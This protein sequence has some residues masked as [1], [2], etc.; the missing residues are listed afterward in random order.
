MP[1]GSDGDPKGINVILDVDG[2]QGPIADL[3]FRFD[4]GSCSGA[5]GATGVGLTHAWVGDLVAKLIAPDFVE[6]TL[7]NRP[8]PPPL[9]SAGVNFCQT[10]LDDDAEAPSIQSI[11]SGGGPF[12]GV[13]R[14]LQRLSAFDG[15]PANGRWLLNIADVEAFIAGTLRAFSIVLRASTPPRCDPP[16]PFCRADLDENDVIDFN[17]LLAFLNL[18]NAGDP[19]ADFSGDGVIDFNDVLAFLNEFNL[20]C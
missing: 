2:F 20:P 11:G 12:T 5:I 7:F 6:V 17:D 10:V 19:R 4:G 3:D 18:F 1:L 9:G 8:G 15:R 13:Y 16:R 14:P